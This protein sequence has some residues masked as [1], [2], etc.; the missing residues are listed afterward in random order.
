MQLFPVGKVYDFMKRRHLFIGLSLFIS[1]MSLV[2]LVYPGPKLGTDFKGGTE[3][4]I[5]FL[6]NVTAEQ[7]TQAV[8][9]NGFSKPDVI[10]VEDFKNANHYLV[11]VEDVSS[12]DDAK[13]AEIEGKLCHGE[14][15]PLIAARSYGHPG[16]WRAL[17]DANGIDDPFRMTPG[18]ALLLPSVTELSGQG[19]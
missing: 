11:R 10:H 16:L 14:S 19:G 4:E 1:I 13:R 8:E 7:I 5:G 12:I 9:R 18:R 3:I 17:A 15:L 2:L 6:G